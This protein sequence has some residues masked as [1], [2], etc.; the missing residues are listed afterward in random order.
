MRRGPVRVLTDG[1]N[2]GTK[3]HDRG[4]THMSKDEAPKKGP[5][6]GRVVGPALSPGVQNG[7]RVGAQNW[8]LTLSDK[9]VPRAQHKHAFL[10]RNNNVDNMAVELD[11]LCKE[12]VFGNIPR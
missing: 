5:P 1:A 9:A 2:F 10:S 8:V 4:P 11:I 12:T 7:V 3:L 6:G